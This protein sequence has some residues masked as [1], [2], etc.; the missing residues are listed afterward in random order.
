MF[1][2]KHGAFQKESDRNTSLPD[3]KLNSPAKT[4]GLLLFISHQKSLKITVFYFCA[5]T[6][7]LQAFATRNFT[8]VFAGI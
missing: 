1:F 7:S 8:T 6:A 3:K 2:Q 5:N 4:T